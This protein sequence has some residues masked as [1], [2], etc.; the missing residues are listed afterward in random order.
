MLLD[1]FRV[2]L[3]KEAQFWRDAGIISDV[4]YQQLTQRYQ[5]HN[6]ETA[7]S[8]RF[9][10]TLMILG[11]ILVSLGIIT[12]IAA[13]WQLITPEI[14]VTLLLSL[15]F[16]TNIIGFYLWQQSIKTVLSGKEPKGRKS[17][18]GKSLLIL[19][20]LLLGIILSL[21]VQT[22][23]INSLNYELLLMWSGGVTLMAYSLRLSMLAI[24]G[25]I[26]LLTSYFTFLSELPYLGNEINWALTTLEHVP[27]LLW[28]IFIPL[29][30]LCKSRSTFV[31]TAIAFII[32][33]QLNIK[34][35]QY[36]NPTSA[37][38]WLA[39]FA[40]TLPPT[41]LWSYN[42]LLF[43]K[44]R[45]KVRLLYFQQLARGLTFIFFGILFYILGFH[46]HWVLPPSNFLQLN[47]SH[48]ASLNIATVIDIS[49]L[50]LIAV[51]QWLY[52]I[53]TIFNNWTNLI[54]LSW[55]TIA[56]L[57]PFWYYLNIDIPGAPIVFFN[58]LLT[59]MAISLICSSI[60]EKRKRQ[61][62]AGIL[63]IGLLILTRML[64]YNTDLLL[65]SLVL[66]TCGVAVI[67]LGMWFEQAKGK[68]K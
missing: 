28:L 40:F 65:L 34:P 4:Q 54:I 60:Q 67:G 25:V 5:I 50:S 57:I 61:F 56:G 16:A 12:F 3:R 38:P 66:T 37:F 55:I 23:R 49:L 48:N 42:D 51:S 36:L 46:S 11:S 47:S 13:N 22:F 27:L 17:I 6:L 20:A 18:L 19:S 14:K 53:R 32:T 7:T 62:W 43:S 45:L 58:A 15:L 35:L 44:L 1:Y 33:L 63:I 26:L 2:K 68:H 64:E 39:S 21:I 41:L 29:A 9:V 52:Q 10:F 24:L 31:L 30:I 8:Y 59:M